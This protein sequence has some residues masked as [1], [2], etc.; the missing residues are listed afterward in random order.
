MQKI[1]ITYLQFDNLL[2]S[3]TIYISKNITKE[4]KGYLEEECISMYIFIEDLTYGGSYIYE[5]PF[6][7][8][9]EDQVVA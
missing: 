4:T 8:P 2:W 6:L 5:W 3:D 1:Y 7:F 9:F